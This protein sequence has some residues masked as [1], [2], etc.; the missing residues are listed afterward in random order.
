MTKEGT[1]VANHRRCHGA[2]G[3]PGDRWK[4]PQG[5]SLCRLFQGAAFVDD[6]HTVEAEILKTE[7]LKVMNDDTKPDHSGNTRNIP[8]DPGEGTGELFP[9]PRHDIPRRKEKSDGEQSDGRR[10]PLQRRSVYLWL[11]CEGWMRFGPFEWLRF[12][13]TANAIIGPAGEVVARKT[14]EYWH[15]TDGRGKG[16]PFSN[17]TITT[18]R[19]HPHA[20]SGSHPKG[21]NNVR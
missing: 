19:E 9:R 13:D 8:S 18:T 2:S 15:I 17:P 4:F 14:G 3:C 20:N 6:S 10:P 7:T 16:M 11:C 12:D 1:N 21:R 5:T